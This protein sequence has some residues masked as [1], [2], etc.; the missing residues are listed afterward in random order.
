VFGIFSTSSAT[1]VTI[2]YTADNLVRGWYKIGDVSN[3]LPLG[4]H[5]DNW[6]FADQ[7]TFDLEHQLWQLIWQA[8]NSDCI[9]SKPNNP[10]GFL[11][12]VSITSGFA[13]N[14]TLSSSQW[15][16]ACVPQC[17][18]LPSDWDSLSW[19]TATEWGRNN[20]PTKIWY[21]VNKGAVQGIS[22][23]AQ[24][25]WTEANFDMQGAPG[26]GDSVFIR[27]TIY[28]A[29]EPSTCMLLLF[30]IV[31]TLGMMYVKSKPQH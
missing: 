14:S 30:G 12:E 8:E 5:Y 15:E 2:N 22:G 11:A 20:D 13:M 10:G 16:V 23:N 19:T 24:W 4:A 6:R 21:R 18:E 29:P 31:G 26:P 1:P 7:F 9:N 28:P 17:L 25:I 27:A 3:P